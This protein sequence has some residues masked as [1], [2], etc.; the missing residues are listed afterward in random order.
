[1][2]STQRPL[3]V[4]FVACA[5]IA[6]GAIAFVYQLRE[7]VTRAAFHYDVVWIEMTEL[8][9][10]VCGI[11]LLRGQN[12]ARWMAL[13]WM[14][15]HVVLSAFHAASEF[16]IHLLFCAVIGWVLFRPAAKRFF[17]NS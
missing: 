14:A 11:F 7:F 6:V 13:A 10:F 8:L 3:S 16:L 4:T 12:W 2:I 15:F 5:Y 1:M 17:E 9:A